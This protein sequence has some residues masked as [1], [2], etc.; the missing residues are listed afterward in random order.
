MPT[1]IIVK[2]PLDETGVNPNNLV[3]GEPHTL[4][5]RKVR[6]ISPTYGAF[7]TGSLVVTDD[8]TQTQL[9]KNVQYFAVE[10][11][12]LPTAKTGKEV[13]AIIIITDQ[14][15]SNSV[16]I[17]YQALGGDFSVSTIA[18]QQMIDKLEL[19]ERPVYWPSI[20]GKP[21]EFPPSAHLHDVGDVYG[22][23]YMVHA[24]ERIKDAIVMGDQLSHD[25]IYRYV[26]DRVEEAIGNLQ[27]QSSGGGG[28]DQDEIYWNAQ[29]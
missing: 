24:L 7:F 29:S 16:S 23:E 6:S 1:P 4:V 13:C 17:S 19:D 18:L 2:F 27:N 14:A 28:G 10:L 5:S 3:Q 9:V 26:D 8:V 11:Y 15:V 25:V 12:E 20:I 21:S 22:F